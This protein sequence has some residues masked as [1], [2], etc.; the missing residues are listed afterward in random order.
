MRREQ[1]ETEAAEIIARARDHAHALVAE[2]EARSTHLVRD[3]EERLAVLRD[4]R[5]GIATY[6]ESLRGALTHAGAL[7][8]DS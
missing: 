2:A 7:G 3:A 1:A 4:E 6:F 8:V 5:D